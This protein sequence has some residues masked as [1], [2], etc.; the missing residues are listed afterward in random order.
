M[1]LV[2]RRSRRAVG[3][4]FRDRLERLDPI[5]IWSAFIPPLALWGVARTLKSPRRWFQSLPAIV[6]VY[7]LVLPAVLFYPGVSRMREIT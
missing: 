2:D 1:G 7:G 4:G 5:A 6:I 3:D